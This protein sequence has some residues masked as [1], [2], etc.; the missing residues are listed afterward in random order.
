MKK[1]NINYSLYLAEKINQ[2]I[3]YSEYLAENLDNNIHYSEY[4]LENLNWVIER[5]IR[6]RKLKI[7]KILN[8]EK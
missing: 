1:N 2:S 5:D 6:N 3:S 7:E 8:G 4:L